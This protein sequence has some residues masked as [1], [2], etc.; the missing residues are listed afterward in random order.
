MP[1]TN[2]IAIFGGSFDPP[3]VGHQAICLWL[4][5]ALNAQEVIVAPTYKHCF[6]KKLT[7]FEHR[8]AMCK[9]MT[10]NLVNV[11]VSKAELHLPQ[12]N[13]TLNLVKFFSKEYDKLAI[14]VGGDNLS[15]IH[16]W[17]KWNE[18]PKLA[19]IIACGRPGYNGETTLPNVYFYP[20]GISTVSSTEVRN[21]IVNKLP[22]T[23]FVT[24]TVE[25]YIN[26]HNLYT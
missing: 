10:A 5:E 2:H 8:L 24:K 15:Q 17:E 18:I 1:L 12:P 11:R 26:E 25:N 20:V 22:L 3:H 4:K 14:V 23:G 6:G 21:K 13:Y 7:N 19:K 16:T 9:E